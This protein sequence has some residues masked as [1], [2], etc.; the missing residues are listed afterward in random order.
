MKT[1]GSTRELIPHMQGALP[2]STESLN[3]LHR[4]CLRI[5]SLMIRDVADQAA[6]A[7]SGWS[8]G[9]RK[10]SRQDLGRLLEE[11]LPI[12]IALY[13]LERLEAEPRLAGQGLADLVRSLLLPCFSISYSH[14]YDLP[15]DPLE[16]VHGRLDWYLDG[17]KG[18]PLEALAMYVATVLGVEAKECM[19][20]GEQINQELTPLWDRRLDLA[21]RYEMG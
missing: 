9:L 6:K 5:Y 15:Q 17:N 14:L 2:A 18:N 3:L 19:P 11:E 10:K 7:A 8:K 13:A 21:F 20:L 4:L 1:P 12:I 16:H